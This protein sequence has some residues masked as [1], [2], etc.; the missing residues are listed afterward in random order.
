[1]KKEDNVDDD[2]IEK[3]PDD[4]KLTWLLTESKQKLVEMR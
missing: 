3:I 2:E 4:E 1:M